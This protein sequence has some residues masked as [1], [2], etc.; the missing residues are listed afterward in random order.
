MPF[1]A[2]RARMAED[3][4]TIAGEMLIEGEPVAHA[5]EEMGKRRQLREALKRGREASDER[6][7]DSLYRQALAGNVTAQ[8][9][10]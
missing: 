6:V 10:W 4:R 2:E 7:V 1:A 8:I 9:F 5:S 3:D